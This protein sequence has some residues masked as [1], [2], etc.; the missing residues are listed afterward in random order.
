[1]L[2]VFSAFVAGQAMSSD[3][4]HWGVAL[5][6]CTTRRPPPRINRSPS[7]PSQNINTSTT[8][9]TCTTTTPNTT[10]NTTS[11]VAGDSANEQAKKNNHNHRHHLL[12]H[13]PSPDLITTSTALR[14]LAAL[15]ASPRLRIECDDAFVQ[16]LRLIT[17][18]LSKSLFQRT[19]S[20]ESLSSVV[21]SR[22]HETVDL[23]RTIEE[24]KE[25]TSQVTMKSEE[26]DSMCAVHLQ[27]VKQQMLDRTK[28]LE[29]QTKKAQRRVNGKKKRA[30]GAMKKVS[31]A[32]TKLK[33]WQSPMDAASEQ[34]IAAQ[35]DVSVLEREISRTR[36]I[37]RK[38]H[39]QR[40]K[41]E[42]E[43]IYFVPETELKESKREYLKVKELMEIS[44]QS[45]K[46]DL[47]KQ[48]E[49]A[50]V[51]TKRERK[52]AQLREDSERLRQ[53]HRD[54]PKNNTPRPDIGNLLPQTVLPKFKCL[55]KNASIVQR[56]SILEQKLEKQLSRVSSNVRQAY[57]Q[58]D[59]DQES[60][61]EDKDP[62]KGTAN[63]VAHKT[64]SDIGEVYDDALGGIAS[65]TLRMA[66]LRLRV[67]LDGAQAKM[68]RNQQIFGFHRSERMIEIGTTNYVVEADDDDDNDDDKHDKNDK[69]LITSKNQKTTLDNYRSTID[70]QLT[71][72]DI[73]Q[74]MAHLVKTL[75]L[76]ACAK[77]A[78]NIRV[79]I[80]KTAS[81]L[82][83]RLRDFDRALEDRERDRQKKGSG[84][85]TKKISEKDDHA[86]VVL[87]HLNLVKVIESN[88]KRAG[89]EE[90]AEKEK[91]KER[92]VR[93]VGLGSNPTIPQFLRTENIDVIV[94]DVRT[95][96]RVE[97]RKILDQLW[98]GKLGAVTAAGGMM[99]TRLWARK[100]ADADEQSK[101][102]Q[103]ALANFLHTFFAKLASKRGTT[104]LIEAYSLWWSM[105]WIS[106]G[107][108]TGHI[109]DCG[110]SFIRMSSHV[111]GRTLPE[112]VIPDSMKMLRSLRSFIV[113]ISRR[114]MGVPAQADM[115]YKDNLVA[116]LG[117]FFPTAGHEV[118]EK[119][120]DLT[121]MVRIIE[122]EHQHS[123]VVPVSWLFSVNSLAADSEHMLLACRA[124]EKCSMFVES[125][126]HYYLN[127]STRYSLRL[128]QLL[129]SL[130]P[131]GD[132]KLTPSMCEYCLHHVLARFHV[133]RE[134]VLRCIS[135][136]MGLDDDDQIN[137]RH[138]QKIAGKPKK[139]TAKSR[140]KKRTKGAAAKKEER[141][142]KSRKAW[143]HLKMRKKTFA[144]VGIERLPIEWMNPLGADQSTRRLDIEP[145]W[146]R[147]VA[148]HIYRPSRF[149]FDG[150]EP[151]LRHTEHP[152][153]PLTE[154]ESLKV[155]LDG[156]GRSNY[157]TGRKRKYLFADTKGKQVVL[158][159]AAASIGYCFVRSRTPRRNISTQTLWK[160]QKREEYKRKKTRGRGRRRSSAGT[161]GAAH[162][163]TAMMNSGKNVRR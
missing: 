150:A 75:K 22:A 148:K 108:E 132:G 128:L 144:K 70:S 47:S 9:A 127:G 153:Q 21:V 145:F 59:G 149:W 162:L 1:M 35:W 14:F 30:A 159:E 32:M 151:C 116:S 18:V 8:I 58:D 102:S 7:F 134:R 69:D 50:A 64:K 57:Q 99:N 130:N 41:L 56:I 89:E 45:Y 97:V 74:R 10:P 156:G 51:A 114:E 158:T 28:D 110:V 106:N 100:E 83:Q 92:L 103:D 113:T 115:L 111:L 66:F 94:K 43:K 5:T 143:S 62:T 160:E 63:L 53:E 26:S 107:Q 24:L 80:L 17:T 38:T 90:E 65:W 39:S 4:L 77:K 23:Q 29:K 139:K 154:T 131:A 93:I 71:S 91:E 12:L 46:Y 72:N 121:Q 82:N 49:A 34:N 120:H 155:I 101:S 16:S 142:N 124:D 60:L 33:K 118:G 2:L 122:K 147:L 137:N 78:M 112:S 15:S 126:L 55:R 125:A 81:T 27:N 117:R 67:A 84:M 96:G 20:G 68:K 152:E 79:E 123:C 157:N 36:Q 119:Y 6:E 19:V 61:A 87:M 85:A 88:E 98:A 140:I 52:A 105:Q 44:K 138:L 109:N 95:M 129:H 136:G 133:S 161:V 42:R 3:F 86:S 11:I 37:T 163:A 48:C 13:H 141:K 31:K 25:L 76:L 73:I 40:V 54:W 146:R 104:S 135:M